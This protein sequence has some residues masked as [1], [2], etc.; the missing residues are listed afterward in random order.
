MIANKIIL[1]YN[2]H[3]YRDYPEELFHGTDH[4]GLQIVIG[5]LL[6]KFLDFCIVV[7]YLVRRIYLFLRN[8]IDTL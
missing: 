5:G 3:V 2:R 4:R 8:C 6:E 7:E 1:I